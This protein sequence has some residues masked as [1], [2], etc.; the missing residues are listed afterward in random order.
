MT[1]RRGG[2]AIVALAIAGVVAA[3]GSKEPTHT[4]TGGPIS[5]RADAECALM[6]RTCCACCASSPS[7]IPVVEREREEA[8][9]ARTSC[10][11]CPPGI[12]CPSVASMGD[13]VARCV[14]GTCK[15]VPR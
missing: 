3:C 4:P 11:A 10:Q 15:A 1:A 9:C 5:C 6:N 8:R 2:V 7:A 14:D 12:D 13:F